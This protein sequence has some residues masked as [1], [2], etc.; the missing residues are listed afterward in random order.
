[1]P[2]TVDTL[3]DRQGNSTPTQVKATFMHGDSERP[4]R[5]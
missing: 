5:K 4:E 1:M 2:V 3:R